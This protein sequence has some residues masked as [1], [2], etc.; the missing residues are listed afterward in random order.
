MVPL[1]SSMACRIDPRRRWNDLSLDDR[2]LYLNCNSVAT[3]FDPQR[4]HDSLIQNNHESRIFVGQDGM[5]GYTEVRSVSSDTR[6]S[7]ETC[8]SQEGKISSFLW[9]GSGS[10]AVKCINHI[11]IL[12]MSSSI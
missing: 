7:T 9:V 4:C 1:F 5:S 6:A 12:L 2:R 11:V 10:P 8:V 3:G